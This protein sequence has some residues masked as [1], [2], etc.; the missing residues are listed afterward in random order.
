MHGAARLASLAASRRGECPA[1]AAAAPCAIARALNRGRR[2]SAPRALARRA[3]PRAAAAAAAVV[4]RHHGFA[5]VTAGP[6]AAETWGCA[7]VRSR[8]ARQHRAPVR[9]RAVVSEIDLQRRDRDAALRGGVGVSALAGLACAARRADPVD[10]LAARVELAN[11][12][13]A[14]VAA[15]ETRDPARQ[16]WGIRAVWGG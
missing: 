6:A 5:L 15:P 16:L 8:S 7:G 9:E 1:C 2:R 10:R 12:R 13:L 14:G 3:R 11:D 4:P